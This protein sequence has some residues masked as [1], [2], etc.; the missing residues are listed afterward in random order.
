[1]SPIQV[2]NLIDRLENIIVT[3]RH[4]PLLRRV[5]VE[6]ERLAAF[7][8]EM[9]VAVPEDVKKAQELLKGADAFI[10]RAQEEANNIVI[11][12]RRHFEALVQENQ[13]TKAAQEKAAEIIQEAESRAASITTKAQDEARSRRQEADQYALDVLRRVEEQLNSIAVNIQKG[14]EALEQQ[15]QP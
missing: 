8:D 1:M 4:L 5:L 3:S 11:E 9:R 12:A 13:V 10:D 14:I 7:I 6:E 15:N 2:L